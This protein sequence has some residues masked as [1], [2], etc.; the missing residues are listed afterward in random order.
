MT[1]FVEDFLA[2]YRAPKN[3]AGEYI[4]PLTGQP[5]ANYQAQLKYESS[6][7]SPKLH[8]DL[9]PM[10]KDAPGWL[11][12]AGLARRY[13][14]ADCF[15]PRAFIPAQCMSDLCDHLSLKTFEDV[16]GFASALSG[17]NSAALLRAISGKIE[18]DASV[19]EKVD[20]D[21]VKS[22]IKA[23]HFELEDI[24]EDKLWDQ[25]DLEYRMPPAQQG[26]ELLFKCPGQLLVWLAE[27]QDCDD[28][29]RAARGWTSMNGLG[30]LTL[31]YCEIN[32]Y[33]ANGG[34][35][36]AHALCILVT[37]Q[38]VWFFEPQN[39]SFHGPEFVIGVGAVKSKIRKLQF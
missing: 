5:F 3:A 32:T 16:K 4:N 33:D 26:K 9:G 19:C 21:T 13:A 30:N 6:F 15:D 24:S 34:Y 12:V 39:N 17:I 1:Q 37:R 2:R 35:V 28:H 23:A 10:T 31:G 20:F 14:G 27:E 25:L 38:G 18:F 11:L 22:L 7:H 8:E 29:A 36:M